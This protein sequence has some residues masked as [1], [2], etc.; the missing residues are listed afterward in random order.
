[1]TTLRRRLLVPTGVLAV[2][3]AGTLGVLAWFSALET[4]TLQRSTDEVRGASALAFA[5]AEA[6]HHDERLVLAIRG[7]PRGQ[8]DARL[9]ESSAREIEI[10]ARLSGRTLAPRTAEIWREYLRARGALLGLRDQILEAAW[11]GDAAG[12]ALAYE[13]W[14]L[15]GDRV[16]GLLENFTALHLRLLD[17]TVNDLQRR[18]ERTLWGA[19][20]ATVVG[21]VLAAGFAI[22]L[23][24]SVVGPLIRMAAAAKSISDGTAS[25]VPGAERSDELGVLARSLN[26][27]TERLVATNERLAEAVRARDEFLSIA[28]HELKTP[29]TPLQLRLEQL[30][31]ATSGDGQLSREALA[32]S[33]DALRRQ[34]KRLAKLVSSLLDVSRITSGKLTLDVQEISAVELVHEVLERLGEEIRAAGCEVVIASGEQVR[35]WG[36]RLRLDQV[37]SN[38]VSNA[39][40]YAPGARVTVRVR[41]I[42]RGVEI[43]VEDDGP[44]IDP[45]DHERIFSRFER[46][47]G[48][49]VNVAGLGLG[50]YIARE[51]ARA[52]GGDLAVE[53][54]IGRGARF[55]LRLRRD[56]LPSPARALGRQIANA[57]TR[58][59]KLPAPP[60]PG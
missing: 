17:A 59:R 13:K 36:D 33:A 49:R 34:V 55:T 24:R 3:A 7:T 50:L 46:A 15:L 48:D 1:V 47:V 4:E 27:M 18:R 5:L 56:P 37:I 32:G 16:A 52:H 44:G 53:S 43:D 19:A 9:A 12:L 41:A 22:T 39:A 29:L 2:V 57:G 28:S 20:A 58:R 8:L 26:G 40:K 54:A 23:A 6:S 30:L 11:R 45:A 31:K 10:V 21:V 35:F 25:R 51:I 14:E 60:E 38:L 42:E